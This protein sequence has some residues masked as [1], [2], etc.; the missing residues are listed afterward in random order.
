MCSACY[1]C[2]HFVLR[3]LACD[4][5][6]HFCTCIEHTEKKKPKTNGIGNFISHFNRKAIRVVLFSTVDA[7][8]RFNALK[9][10]WYSLSFGIVFSIVVFENGFH[11]IWNGFDKEFPSQPNECIQRIERKSKSISFVEHCANF[12]RL[13]DAIKRNPSAERWMDAFCT[14]T[15]WSLCKRVMQPFGWA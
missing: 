2:L 12:F 11:S 9:I 13:V 1:R 4:F 10:N 14:E 5:G 7:H 15:L 3:D 6:T 8:N